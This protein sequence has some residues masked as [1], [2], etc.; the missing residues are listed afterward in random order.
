MAKSAGTKGLI[1]F[2]IDGCLFQGESW[3]EEDCLNAKPIPENIEKCNILASTGY[4]VILYTARRPHLREATEKALYLSNVRYH[5]LRM[6]KCPASLYIDDKA[7]R[8]EELDLKDPFKF[9]K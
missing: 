2:D 1:L 5:A 8:P 4:I 7:I 9:I 3:T 6:D